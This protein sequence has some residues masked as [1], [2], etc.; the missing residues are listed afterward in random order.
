MAIRSTED[1]ARIA[2]TESA[3]FEQSNARARPRKVR[4]L[5]YGIANRFPL[6]F[7]TRLEQQEKKVIADI[8]KM[9]KAGQM[10]R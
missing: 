8:K 4:D 2:A 9:A 7:R 5:S 10:V 3:R 1:T 6:A